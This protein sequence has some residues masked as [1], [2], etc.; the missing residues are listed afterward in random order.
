MTG[1]AE[2]PSLSLAGRKQV[3]IVFVT[4]VLFRLFDGTESQVII[5]RGR[6]F[7]SGRGGTILFPAEHEQ[8]RL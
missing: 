6:F 5:S 8:T 4:V 7:G 3:A 2:E 1:Q